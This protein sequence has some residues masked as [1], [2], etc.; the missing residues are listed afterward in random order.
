[1]NIDMIDTLSVISSTLCGEV[2]VLSNNNF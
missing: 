1:M 2:S